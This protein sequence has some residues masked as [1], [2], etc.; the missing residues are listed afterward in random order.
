MD[1]S[2]TTASRAT[3]K[4]FVITNPDK[5]DSDSEDDGARKRGP[6]RPQAPS[7]PQ[8]QHLTTHMHMPRRPSHAGSIAT[9][10]PPSSI[11]SPIDTTTPPSTP[12]T[13]SELTDIPRSHADR[14]DQST[15]GASR[16]PASARPAPEIPALVL[17]SLNHHL[18][19][20]KLF[21]DQSCSPPLLPALW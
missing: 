21:T 4:V 18:C 19:S 13:S 14:Q 2:R 12:G 3:R 10:S 11:S 20:P 6:Y 15:N 1:D 16:H 8:L 7:G 17:V 9:Q 5:S